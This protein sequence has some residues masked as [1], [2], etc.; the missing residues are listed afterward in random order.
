MSWARFSEDSAVYVFHDVAGYIRCCACCLPGDA[1]V[2]FTDPALLKLHLLAHEEAGHAVPK[3][4]WEAFRV[5]EEDP[6]GY[7][8]R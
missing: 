5:F 1:P 3:R 6:V 8:K 7:L 2:S 4:C